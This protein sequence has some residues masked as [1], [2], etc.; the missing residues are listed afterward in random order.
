MTRQEHLDWCKKRALEYVDRG[1]M[2][3]AYASMVSDLNKHEE[4]RNHSAI[5]LGMM[6]MMGGYLA[7]KEEMTKFINGFN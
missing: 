6:L 1:D 2:K 3:N 4:T 5:Q 7:K